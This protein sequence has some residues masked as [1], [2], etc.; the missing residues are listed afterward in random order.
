MNYEEEKS[1]IAEVFDN[2]NEARM[3]FEVCVPDYPHPGCLMFS[4][5][6][7]QTSDFTTWSAQ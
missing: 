6:W 4:L 7:T 1:Q 5:S 3:Q 2:V